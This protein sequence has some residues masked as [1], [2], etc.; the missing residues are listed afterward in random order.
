[1]NTGLRSK[2]VKNKSLLIEAVVG[3]AYLELRGFFLMYF[4]ETQTIF[5]LNTYGTP[6]DFLNINKSN[7][8]AAQY[9]SCSSEIYQKP[10]DVGSAR[11]SI[12]WGSRTYNLHSYRLQCISVANTTTSY[13]C[14]NVSFMF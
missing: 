8:T 6:F 2:A 1:M 14:I 12:T 11:C 5:L 9:D 10:A 13:L 3:R 7:M 4:L